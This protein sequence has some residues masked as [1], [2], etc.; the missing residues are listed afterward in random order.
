MFGQEQ[1]NEIRSGADRGSISSFNPDMEAEYFP[2]PSKGYFFTGKYKGITMVKIK[3]M[4]WVEEDILTTQSYYDND[5]LFYEILKSVIVDPNFPVHEIVPIDAN[6]ILW[7]LRIGTFGRNY[8]VPFICGN[9]SCEK[10]FNITW[11]LGSF[12]V[13]DYD[14]Q[15][16]EELQENEFITVTHNNIEYQITS[17]KIG[18]EIDVIRF[19]ERKGLNKSNVQTTSKLLLIVNKIKDNGEVIEGLFKIHQWLLKRRIPLQDSRFIQECAKKITL[20][21]NSDQE[22]TCPHC[23]HVENLSMPMSKNFFGLNSQGYRTYLIESIN[24]LHFW[25]KLDYHSILLMPT[26]KRKIWLDFTTKNLETLYPKSK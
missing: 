4:S 1:Q 16:E 8:E 22:V 19:L 26:A 15:H 23:N 3:K 7:W 10:Q 12:E 20:E 11:D 18:N 6:A 14:I 24:F 25:G 2:L 21:V 9:S 17:P 5:M 13:P